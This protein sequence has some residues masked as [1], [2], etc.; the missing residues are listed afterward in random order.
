MLIAVV[1]M[2]SSENRTIGIFVCM[3]GKINSF[4]PLPGFIII[5]RD[6]VRAIFV[7]DDDIY[8]SVRFS[9]L[10]QLGFKWRALS[11]E[12]GFDEFNGNLYQ[13]L[14]DRNSVYSCLKISE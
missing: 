3:T 6:G 13:Y 1:D 8:P 14:F 10:I 9:N 11:S 4:D 2:I 7:V 5:E 12:I